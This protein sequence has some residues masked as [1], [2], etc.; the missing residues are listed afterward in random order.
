MQSKL[1]AGSDV[2]DCHVGK[3]HANCHV[4]IHILV[5]DVIVDTW[6]T[7]LVCKGFVVKDVVTKFFCKHNI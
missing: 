6:T 7:T 5:P 2:A 1:T 4:T 3:C